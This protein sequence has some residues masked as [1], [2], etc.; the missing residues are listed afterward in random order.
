MDN[1]SKLPTI[2]DYLQDDEWE[3]MN[4]YEWISVK[5]R[6]PAESP[7]R[8]I[9]IVTMYSGYKMKRFVEPLHYIDSKW[10]TMVHEEPL[11]MEY[12]VT[13]WMPLPE[14]PLE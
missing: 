6:L 5:D 11:D 4:A 7:F 8:S 14:A 2:K 1:N 3:K 12:E 13:H 9:Y 10:Y